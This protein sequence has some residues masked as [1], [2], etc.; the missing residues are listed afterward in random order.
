MAYAD[1]AAMIASFGQQEMVQLTVRDQASTG[2][3]DDAVLQAALSA[4]DARIDASLQVRY[5]LPLKSTPLVVMQVACD[6]ARYFLYDSTPTDFVEKRY[7]EALKTLKGFSNGSLK[8]GLDAAGE[9]SRPE[10]HMQMVSSPRIFSR[11][12]TKG[13]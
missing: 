11:A 6:L 10:H 12:S 8:L 5:T 3:I 1:K 9:P 7:E 13:Y 2:V 4:A